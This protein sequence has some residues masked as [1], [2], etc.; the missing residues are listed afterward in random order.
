[1]SPIVGAIPAKSREDVLSNPQYPIQPIITEGFCLVRRGM[2]GKGR[3]QV[4]VS[5]VV[6][7]IAVFALFYGDK[8]REKL[9]KEIITHYLS[10][11]RN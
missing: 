5:D 2:S 11:S 10:T 7:E 1:M 6:Y 3:L 8:D 4:A 9:I